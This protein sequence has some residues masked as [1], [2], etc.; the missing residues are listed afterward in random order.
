MIDLYTSY[1]AGPKRGIEIQISRTTPKGYL[2][3]FCLPELAPLWWMTIPKITEAE[4]RAEYAK[5]LRVADMERIL[6]S[7]ALWCDK[8]HASQ[9]TLLC[10]EKPGD[11][12][13]RHLV[14]DWLRNAGY[15][16][17]EIKPANQQPAKPDTPNDTQLKLF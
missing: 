11:F 3:E 7:I 2:A 14:A 16:I 1:Y 9:A 10:W 15:E 17:S 5:I 13:H 6:D 8:K 12:C 4:Y